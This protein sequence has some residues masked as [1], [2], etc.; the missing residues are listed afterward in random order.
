[1]RISRSGSEKSCLKE[2]S[3]K[4]S[5]A[6]FLDENGFEEKENKEGIRDPEELEFGFFNF[7]LGTFH[8]KS[9]LN[10]IS[11]FLIQIFFL[12]NYSFASLASPFGP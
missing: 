2:R 11:N 10:Y 12:S 8:F 3:N 4:E 1:V 6:F 9:V 7:Q 5:V